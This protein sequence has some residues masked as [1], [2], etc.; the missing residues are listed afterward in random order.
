MLKYRI[1]ECES[2]TVVGQAIQLTNSQK[3]NLVLSKRFWKQFNQNIKK[4]YLFQ[5]QH[6]TKY[7]FMIRR[8]NKLYYYCAL[9]DQGKV[10]EHF[11]TQNILKQKYLVFE[12]IGHM[13]NIYMTY[14]HIYLKVIPHC[15][16]QV[17]KEHFLHFE[18]YNNRFH[19]NHPDSVIE[20]WIPI[21][22]IQ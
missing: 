3:H 6:W 9:P 19:W 2:F 5:G 16:Y 20:I 21:L 10:P 15:P 17:N 1:E 22:D 8:N 13:D 14:N 18:K 11:F 12:H 7:A 4:A